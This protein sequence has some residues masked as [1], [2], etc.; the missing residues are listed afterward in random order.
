MACKKVMD[1]MKEHF[2]ERQI[3]GGQLTEA[4]IRDMIANAL[5]EPMKVLGEQI[6]AIAPG[7]GGG[8]AT[9]N[10]A[11]T[12]QSTTTTAETNAWPLR[13]HENGIF[14]R[15]PQDFQFPR[16]GVYDLWLR[17][18]RGDTERGIPPLRILSGADYRFLDAVPKTDAEKRGSRGPKKDNRRATKRTV[19]DM[20]FLCTHIENKA[21]DDGLDIN[22]RGHTN[23]KRTHDMVSKDLHDGLCKKKQR[24]TALKWNAICDKLRAKLREDK[25]AAANKAAEMAADEEDSCHTDNER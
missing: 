11:S 3:G 12:T 21:H 8:S 15:L 16:S 17:W 2:E 5:T 18:N 7:T 9:N 23:L 20:K 25:A 22:D 13:R 1:G 24:G 19:C 4:R 6:K 10:E 14:S